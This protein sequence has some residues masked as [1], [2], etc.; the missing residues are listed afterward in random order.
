MVVVPWMKYRLPRMTPSWLKFATP[1]LQET[2]PEAAST[3][4]TSMPLTS[5]SNVTSMLLQL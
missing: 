1:S 3:S 2:L 5:R 4:C